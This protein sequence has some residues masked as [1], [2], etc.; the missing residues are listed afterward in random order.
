MITCTL[1]HS[2]YASVVGPAFPEGQ[3]RQEAP[4]LKLLVVPVE[5]RCDLEGGLGVGDSLRRVPLGRV[6][7]VEDAVTLTGDPELFPA[8]W[9]EID[10]SGS[11]FFCSYLQDGA[12]IAR[13]SCI[14]LP[15]AGV[16]FDTSPS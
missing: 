13:H 15:S 7:L 2:L 14:P 6:Y 5:R 11:G 1:A 3:L 12:E 8:G 9:E 10:R 4:V 16:R